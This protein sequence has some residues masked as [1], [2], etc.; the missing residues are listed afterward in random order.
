MPPTTPARAPT[1]TAPA[2][3]AQAT[4]T[5]H[6]VTILLGWWLVAG[7]FIDGWAHNNLGDRLE[8]FFTPWHAI[9][10]SGFAA[11]AGW[12]LHLALLGWRG[13]RRGLAAFPDGY[14]L[15]ALGV[16]LFGVSGLGD[17]IWHTVFGIEVGIDALLSPTHLG[18][19][20]GATLILASPLNATWRSGASRTA[21]G[22]QR[23]VAVLSAAS[24]LAITAFMQMYLW[25][26]L[27]VPQGYGGNQTRGE[28]AAILLTAVILAAPPLLLLRRFALP[29]GAVTV[30]YVAANTA[31]A[32][33]L[34]PGDWR[35]PG[36]SVLFG[37]LAD[38]LHAALRPSPRR[39][40]A[41]RAYAL[42]L[43]LCVWVPYLGS[44]VR[45]GQSSLSLELWLGV[46]V[47]AAL[48]GL[49]LSA[50][51]VPAP[52]PAAALEDA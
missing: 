18:L 3:P 4:T 34:V 36:L 21:G 38:A 14:H 29:F 15:A 12:C 5:Q 8:T 20:L 48:G 43:P 2:G 44:L 28:L 1:A 52:L 30:M 9:F 6:L 16:P 17:M 11:V 31:M 41:L 46:S 7:L 51:I 10:Y 50:L 49:A 35:L 26:L 37:L 42:A 22:A 47:M 13:G 19:F 32:V 25:A 33:M 45:L 39:V 27:Y 40:W 24:L 23:W